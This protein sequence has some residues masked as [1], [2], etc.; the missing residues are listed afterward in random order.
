MPEAAGRR[1]VSGHLIA[2]RPT[3]R[4]LGERHE[5]HVGEGGLQQV[6]DEIVGE[7]AV[8]ESGAPGCDVELVHAHGRVV[9][10]GVRALLQP[11]SVG[12]LV[13]RLADD[14]C[15]GRR[16]LGVPGH[17]VGA[18]H[19]VT[20]GGAQLELV[21]RAGLESGDEQL[22]DAV[23]VEFAHR[24]SDA[25]PTVE[26]ADD[27]GRG[28]VRSPHAERGSLDVFVGPVVGSENVPHLFVSPFGEEI[29]IGLSHRRHEAVGVFRDPGRPVLVGGLELVG[30]AGTGQERLPETVGVVLELHVRAVAAH[31]RHRCGQRAGCPHD[32]AIVV[33]VLAERVVR[34]RVASRDDRFNEAGVQFRQ[35][36]SGGRRSARLRPRRRLRGGLAGAFAGAFA[37]ALLAGAFAG[38]SAAGASVAASPVAAA[39]AGAFARD[40]GAAFAGAAASV[41]AGA[42]AEAFTSAGASAGVLAAGAFLGILAISCL[43]GIRLGVCARVR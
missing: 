31:G 5:L 36:G 4:M 32:E 6:V 30:L 11:V 40:L 38:A 43:S 2:P 41:F 33:G 25:V 13:L 7:L 9:R 37:A 26:V 35:V 28:G 20:L 3:E 42:S 16:L 39:L 34:M 27:P 14:G 15:G 24:V 21:G 8:A 19:P 18:R 1:E 12:P 17:R 10:V 23:V 29:Q 22:P